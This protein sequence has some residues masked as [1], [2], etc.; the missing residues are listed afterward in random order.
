MTQEERP[1]RRRRRSE[2]GLAG[3]GFDLAASVGVGTLIGWW[4][5]RQYDTEPWG[6]V[7]CAM[8]GIVGGLFYF[9]KVGHRAARRAEREQ[10]ERERE[11]DERAG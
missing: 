4:I 8:I 9:A 5:D 3:M 2:M 7:V 11:R 1:K 6:L 10:E